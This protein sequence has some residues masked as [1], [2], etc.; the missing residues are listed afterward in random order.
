MS[1]PTMTRRPDHDPGYDS[2]LLDLGANVSAERA[3]RGWTQAQA[4]D[5][6]GIDIKQYQ[7]VEYGRRALSTRSLYRI[8][9]AFGLRVVDLLGES[10]QPQT[11]ATMPQHQALIDAGWTMLPLTGRRKQAG[12][13]PV[14]DLQPAAG[15]PETSQ[16]PQP[17]AWALPP[18]GW[19]RQGD[20]LFLARVV[21]DSMAPKIP[22]GAWCLF[23]QPATAPLLGKIVLCR[24]P[25]GGHESG[26]W[27]C[28]LVGGVSLGDAHLQLRLDSMGQHHPVRWVTLHDEAD[29]GAL[30]E[31]LAV[32]AK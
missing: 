27:L 32:V 7:D 21:G 31:W 13:I 4:A 25:D 2:W 8:A 19:R 18:A 11:A 17:V 12:A 6:C 16:Q 22:A 23:R 9:Q 26:A 5:A 24:V 28:K 10:L 3:R 14:L 20:G 30:G 15:T 1:L 29:L